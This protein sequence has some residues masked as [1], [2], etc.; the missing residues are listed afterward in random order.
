[1]EKK[2][3]KDVKKYIIPGIAIIF[4][5]WSLYVNIFG[6]VPGMVLRAWH[7]IFASILCFTLQPFSKS[8]SNEKHARLNSIISGILLIGSLA[9]GLHII[10]KS[11]NLEAMQ[12]SMGVP[13]L[14]DKIMAVVLILVVLEMARR[15]VG[16]GIM[17][18]TVLFIVYTY[19]G[20]Y[21]PG[22]FGHRS[23]SL[24][25]MLSHFYLSLEGVYGFTLGLSATYVFIFVLFASFVQNSYAGTFL[26]NLAFALTRRLHGGPAQAAVVSSAFMGSLSGAATANVVGTGSITIPLMMKT[27]FKPHVAAAIEAAASTGGGVTPPMLGAAAFIIAE[28][29]SI[30]YIAIVKIS[31]VPAILYFTSV[32]AFIHFRSIKL[33]IKV[34][35]TQSRTIQ[36]MKDGIH[37]MV[38]VLV[39]VYF[40][41][42]SYTP[43]LAAF[44]GIVS[45]IAISYIR[46]HSR[47]GI[48][49]ILEALESGAK[50]IVPIAAAMACVGIIIGCIGMTGIGIKFSNMIISAAGTNLLLTLVFIMIAALILGMGLPITAAYITL[51][52][53]A[54][55]ALETGGLPILVGHMIIFWLSQTSAVTP[56]VCITS[57][58]AA[59]IANAD[60]MKTAFYGFRL[61]IGLF[62]MP[63]LFAYTPLISGSFF[64]ILSTGFFVF[65]GIIALS[66]FAE[67]Y[68]FE[69]L[70]LIETVF[71]AATS[72][73]LLYPNV[74]T[75]VGGLLL[76]AGFIVIQRKRTLTNEPTT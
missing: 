58:A 17:I 25:R 21:L 1:M 42:K 35:P 39:L 48:K 10:F 64:E 60:P 5:L 50:N 51:A 33:G 19:F 54:G 30:P 65:L 37:F 3:Y 7:L 26:I 40:L 28:W 14:L 38:P 62:I 55:P 46:K 29:L 18:I 66:S 32:A 71:M 61:A 4:S 56:P 69:K 13:T 16:Y 70:T 8:V 68:F 11:Q 9:A 75:H 72:S 63:V 57:Y 76:F 15:T 59:G 2:S 36:V 34:E 52:I 49:N 31:I 44:T 67:R 45:L 12:S 23:P 74:I 53:F 41:A 43:S 73:L 6:T 20:S 22:I 47:L 27:G 24:G